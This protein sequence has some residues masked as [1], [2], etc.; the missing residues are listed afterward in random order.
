MTQERKDLMDRFQKWLDTN[1]LKSIIAAECTN[2]AEE[3][4]AIKAQEFAEQ[5]NSD[6]WDQTEGGIWMNVMQPRIQES[7]RKTTD[8]L[9]NEFNNQMP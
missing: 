4:A 2:I 5:L 9:F 7:V 6:G 3:Y 1:P 8:Q